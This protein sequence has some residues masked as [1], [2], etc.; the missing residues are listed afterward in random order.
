MRW[1]ALQEGKVYVKQSLNA[2]QY[3]IEDL[4]KMLENNS[5]VADRIIWFGED[6]RES[7]QFWYRYQSELSDM[8]KQLGIQGMVFF[9]FSA[10]D[11]H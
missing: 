9:T 6:L 8:I 11:F 4:Q 7:R 3:T 2:Q 1:R 10:A 5:Y